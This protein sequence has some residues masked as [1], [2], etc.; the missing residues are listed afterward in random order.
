MIHLYSDSRCIFSHRARIILN[1]KDMDFKIVDVN[2]NL[3]QDL[4][5]LNPYNQTPVLVDDIDKNNKKKDLILSDTNIICEYI[6]ER[7]PHPQLMPIEPAEKSRLRMLM[8]HFENELFQHVRKFESMIG[9]NKVKK[10][11]EKLRKTISGV[12]DNLAQ[13]FIHDKK[14]QYLFGNSFT[15]LD[16]AVLPLLWRLD[17]YE[18]ETKD[19][20]SGI[21]KYANNMFASE[22]FM[23][24]LTPAERSMRE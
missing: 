19:S 20:W 24:S 17:Y 14:A 6:D 10:E 15:I 13:V 2:I 3:R 11:Q 8:H 1:K 21:L 22:E 23:A 12:L 5:V 16:A 18:I 7:F 9:N 4:M